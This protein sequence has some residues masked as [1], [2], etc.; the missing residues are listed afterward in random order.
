MSSSILLTFSWLYVSTCSATQLDISEYC[1]VSP[2]NS[3]SLH[4]SS[5]LKST[6]FFT[7]SLSCSN[8][9]LSLPLLWPSVTYPLHRYE[10]HSPLLCSPYLQYLELYIIH[11][12]TLY[13]SRPITA[14]ELKEKKEVSELRAKSVD[15][16][17]WG[18]HARYVGKEGRRVVFRVF[19]LLL[20]IPSPA[21]L[22]RFLHGWFLIL[23][24]LYHSSFTPQPSLAIP[25]LTPHLTTLY[26]TSPPHQ[27]LL[28]LTT[29]SLY[30]P[31]WHHLTSPHLP[32]TLYPFS[33]PS[34]PSHHPLPI[35]PYRDRVLRALGS[36]GFT[37]WLKIRDDSG[38]ELR[39]LKVCVWVCVRVCVC[40]CVCV[41]VWERERERGS[42]RVCVHVCVSCVTTWNPNSSYPDRWV[43][44]SIVKSKHW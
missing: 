15:V 13:S 9:L 35:W 22:K 7:L 26:H 29:L 28:L 12:S 27:P 3:T 38:G 5:L 41:C 6:F 36:Y 24:S 43:I 17:L 11:P 42:V 8:F 14:Q 44:H 4:P 20:R 33:P 18:S 34:T 40:V 19:L 1:P 37:R 25:H 23:V 2:C 39:T 16:S 30:D 10:S 31:I 32:T 21:S